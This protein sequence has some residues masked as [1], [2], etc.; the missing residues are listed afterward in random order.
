MPF[1]CS[2]SAG[3]DLSL[4]PSS[5]RLLCITD[6][7]D[8][9]P[10]IYSHLNLAHGLTLFTRQIIKKLSNFCTYFP[11]R[12]LSIFESNFFFYVPEFSMFLIL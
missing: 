10:H 9:G 2:G 8:H 7:T 1:T 12:V 5:P 3:T 11:I 4:V 6:V